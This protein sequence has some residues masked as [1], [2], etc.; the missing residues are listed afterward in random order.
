MQ[1]ILGDDLGDVTLPN[2]MASRDFLSLLEVIEKDSD[3]ELFSEWF[4]YD[5]LSKVYL[6]QPIRKEKG[7][8][9]GKTAW[10]SWIK[11]RA[12]MVRLIKTA[13]PEDLLVK[14]CKPCK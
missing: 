8:D 14:Y 4:K 6:L 5:D 11:A 3:K 7:S 1:I 9:G 2:Q 12:H 10:G 13:L